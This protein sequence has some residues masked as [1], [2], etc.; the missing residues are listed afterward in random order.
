MQT[1]PPIGYLIHPA[2][3][4]FQLDI[5]GEWE[6]PRFPTL[7]S[8]VDAAWTHRRAVDART[9]TAAVDGLEGAV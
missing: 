2:R 5:P 1:N 7:Q 8:A 6:M 3:E 9:A 4:T